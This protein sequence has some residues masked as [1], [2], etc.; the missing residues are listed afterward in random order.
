[1]PIKVLFGPELDWAGCYLIELDIS[2]GDEDTDNIHALSSLT[3]DEAV[4][5][6]AIDLNQNQVI[7]TDAKG[8]LDH[9]LMP[10]AFGEM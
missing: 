1:M 9:W 7:F 5:A 8:K 4:T 2:D 3:V 10:M 6:W